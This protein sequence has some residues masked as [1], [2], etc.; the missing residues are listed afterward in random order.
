MR[1]I[2][3]VVHHFRENWVSELSDGKI[4][5]ACRDLGMNWINSLLDPVK[6]IQIFLLQVLFGN[7]ACVH[8]PRLTGM[9][10]TAVGYCKARL[11]IKLKVFQLLLERCVNQLQRRRLIPASG[12][13][14]EF[15]C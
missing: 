1:S 11:R 9:T 5:Q 10:F 7:T 15:Y 13:A 6:T 14:T 4:E 8:M 2:S 12:L 3:E